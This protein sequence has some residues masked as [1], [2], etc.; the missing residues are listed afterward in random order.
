MQRT[1]KASNWHCCLKAK[2]PR[3]YNSGSFSLVFKGYKKNHKA[4]S[5]P[6]AATFRDNFIKLILLSWSESSYQVLSKLI[7]RPSNYLPYCSE[8]RRLLSRRWSWWGRWAGWSSS[9]PGRRRSSRARS[10]WGC[11][12]CPRRAR[13]CRPG[14]S[15][16]RRCRRPSRRAGRRPTGRK[17]PIELSMAGRG[18]EWGI[19]FVGWKVLVGYL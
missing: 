2:Y 19:F 4:I 12:W 1:K 7:I 8:L 15:W 18:E 17:C 16:S 10:G 5:F 9:A 14:S 3:D 13:G 11:G 6:C